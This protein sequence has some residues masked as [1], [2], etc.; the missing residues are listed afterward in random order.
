M[1]WRSVSWLILSVLFLCVHTEVVA[2]P[3]EPAET[4][5]VAAALKMYEGRWVG[6][7]TIH[8]T[9]SGYSETFPV[10]QQYWWKDGVLHGV[11]VSQ[12]EVGMSSAR[13]Q[14][15][16]KEGK[17]FSEVKV[18]EVVENYFGVLHDGGIVWLS[19]NLKRTKDYQ[20]KESIV[21]VDG[22]RVLMTE[23]FDTYVYG[24]GIAHLVYRGEL[25]L[26]E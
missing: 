18:G 19:T 21:E 11:A 14:S 15:V 4:K 3:L 2:A 13:S 24:E 22:E 17:Y 26:V 20:M 10:E 25:K 9:A 8:S 23:G 1:I 5:A 6:H 12:R 16:A 7:F